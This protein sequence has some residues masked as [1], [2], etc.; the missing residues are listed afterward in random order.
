MK[1]KEHIGIKSEEFVEFGWILKKNL[2]NNL[3]FLIETSCKLSNAFYANFIE[4]RN[5][6]TFRI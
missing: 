2:R 3:M 5:S 6:V 1:F 4:N